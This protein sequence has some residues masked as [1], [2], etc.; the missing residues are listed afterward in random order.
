MVRRKISYTFFYRI[1]AVALIILLQSI[2]ITCAVLDDAFLTKKNSDLLYAHMF[3]SDLTQDFRQIFHWNLTPAPYFFPDLFV[4]FFIRCNDIGITLFLYVYLFQIIIYI[5]F[6]KFFIHSGEDNFNYFDLTLYYASFLFISL[7]MNQKLLYFYLPTYHSS[8]YIVGFL[9]CFR[10]KN[11]FYLFTLFLL[12]FLI[13]FSDS[14]LILQIFIPFLLYFFLVYIFKYNSELSLRF[15]LYAL[16]FSIIGKIVLQ[17]F[18]SLE[19]LLVPDPPVFKTLRS[20][21]RH[22]LVTEN[23]LKSFNLYLIDIKEYKIGF[24]L[25]YSLLI[26]LLSDFLRNKIQKI[27]LIL[28]IVLFFSFLLIYIF[29]GIFGLWIGYRYMWFY[30]IVPPLGLT[31]YLFLFFDINN[32]SERVF[33]VMKAN[34]IKLFPYIISLICIGFGFIYKSTSVE[35]IYQQYTS[36]S[37]VTVF[38]KLPEIDYPEQKIIPDLVKCLLELKNKYHISYGMSDY[39]NSKFIT[40]FSNNQ[41][42]VNSFQEDL[43]PYYWINNRSHYDNVSYTNKYNFVLTKDLNKERIEKLL[44][45]P[46][47]IKFCSEDEVWIYVSH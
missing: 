29:Q 15:T 21:V 17:F 7:L 10:I 3:L 47:S 28:F 20:I 23:L 37:R 6:Y 35:K 19:W 45:T 43:K 26:I 25:F 27:K 22:Q 38:E 9:L 46:K 14:L 4:Y 1:I 12:S 11:N 31:Y 30:Y 13:G 39:W 36:S 8:I 33:S 41:L 2:L 5:I 32:L 34:L 16:I 44:G 42:L 40:F 24:I 18:I